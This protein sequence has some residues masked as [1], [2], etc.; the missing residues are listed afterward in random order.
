MEIYLTRMESYLTSILQTGYQSPQ[1]HHLKT[2]SLGA[3]D[4]SA[5]CAVNTLEQCLDTYLSL[6]VTGHL[7]RM[8]TIA[9]P[10]QLSQ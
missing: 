9:F 3:V 10:G 4:S 7:G 6:Q 2:L 8:Q 5:W 1:G